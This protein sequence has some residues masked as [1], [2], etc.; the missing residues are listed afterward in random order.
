MGCLWG[1]SFGDRT[2]RDGDVD[3]VGGDGREV[4]GARG[5]TGTGADKGWWMRVRK[6]GEQV[7]RDGECLGQAGRGGEVFRPVR[8]GPMHW[9]LAL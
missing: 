8:L 9:A 7:L 2:V 1:M 4:K 3:G 6:G 5:S